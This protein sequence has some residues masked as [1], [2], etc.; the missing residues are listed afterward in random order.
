MASANHDLM[1]LPVYQEYCKKKL[2]VPCYI[3]VFIINVNSVSGME[4]SN[5]IFLVYKTRNTFN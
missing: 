5:L 2:I 1:N 4:I 3:F